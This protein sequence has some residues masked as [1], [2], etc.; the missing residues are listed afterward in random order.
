VLLGL[1][2]FAAV[3]AAASLVAWMLGSFAIRRPGPFGAGRLLTL[4]LFP[5]AV[6]SVFML[7]VFLPA[8]W[9]FEPADSNES[10][11]VVLGAVAAIG[12]WLVLGAAGRALRAGLAGHRLAALVRRAARL[13]VGNRS[14][15]FVLFVLDGLPGVSLNGIWR[16]RILIG[17]EAL[18]AL[19]PSELDLAISHEIAHRR[20]RD[21]LKRLLMFCTPDLFGWTVVSRQLEE[22]W[23]AEAECGA[24]AHAVRVDRHRAVVL[25]AALVKVARLGCVG[26]LHP[27]SP[28]MT[29]SAL[30][31][32]KLLEMRVR[33]LVSGSPLPPVAV[34]KMGWPRAV[35]GLGAAVGLWLL[36]FSDALHLITEAM[37]TRLP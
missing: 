11:G 9:R 3:N 37:V 26:S 33:R 27:I 21:N 13:E 34:G 15:S 29:S 35:L 10:F 6:S 12:L 18:A 22:R 1:V 2:W 32:P 5:A 14:E 30:H 19:T 16:P 17:W 24:D 36:G 23:Q 20:S 8:H 7:A 4:R 25:A 31:V 28:A